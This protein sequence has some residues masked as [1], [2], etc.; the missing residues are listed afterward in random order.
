MLQYKR[1][2]QNYFRGTELAC[3]SPG[4][5]MHNAKNAKE[6]VPDTIACHLQSM[7]KII[8]SFL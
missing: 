1:H 4:T 6:V 8:Y 7:Q 5:N 3:L 2:H